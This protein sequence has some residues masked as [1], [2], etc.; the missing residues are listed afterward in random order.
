MLDSLLGKDS[1]RQTARYTEAFARHT[2]Y[3][4]FTDMSRKFAN[5]TL[6]ALSQLCFFL[7]YGTV[8]TLHV[9]AIV[10]IVTCIRGCQESETMECKSAIL[11]KK[12]IFELNK[13]YG[14]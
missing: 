1:I 14:I 13:S 3:E 5:Y 4:R 9:V 12:M 6:H 2:W 7:K 8:N 11:T 10:T